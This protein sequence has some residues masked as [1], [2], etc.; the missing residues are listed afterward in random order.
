L[1]RSI[2]QGVWEG[3]TYQEI[4]DS[5]DRTEGHIR[6]SAATLWQDI[7]EAVGRN[8]RKLNFKSIVREFV[9]LRS[10]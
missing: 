8:V 6:D 10:N 7:S 4:A 3:K 2:V 5:T 9:S 1:Q